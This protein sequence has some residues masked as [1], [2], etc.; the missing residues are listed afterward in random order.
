MTTVV[1]PIRLLIRR[2]MSTVGRAVHVNGITSRKDTAT[3]LH[4]NNDPVVQNGVPVTIR[5]YK[6]WLVGVISGTE[7]VVL[8]T[9]HMGLW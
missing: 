4:I 8:P 1:C 9:V 6:L 2:K 3:E 5:K 7:T